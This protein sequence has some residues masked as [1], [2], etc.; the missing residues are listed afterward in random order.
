MRPRGIC[1]FAFLRDCRRFAA[2]K[3]EKRARKEKETDTIA[4]NPIPIV[5]KVTSGEPARGRMYRG[6]REKEREDYRV[7]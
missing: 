4:G 7:Q 3:G 5:Q 1:T 2:I 6:V